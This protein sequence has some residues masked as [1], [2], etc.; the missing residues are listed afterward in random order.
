MQV[1]LSFGSISINSHALLNFGASTC[2]IDIAFIRAHKFP[3]IRTTQPISVEAINGWFL[4]SG[5]V[6]EATVRL[7]FQVGFHQEVLTFCLIATPR[8]S[9]VLGLSWLETHN[10]MVDWC[11]RSITFPQAPAQVLSTNTRSGRIANN[12][13]DKEYS[14]GF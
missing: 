14:V 12:W 10:P 3:I 6:T 5:A 11:T 7:V 1:S 13:K 2:F 8:H 9:I 4:S